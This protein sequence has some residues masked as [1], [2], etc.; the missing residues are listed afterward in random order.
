VGE[1]FAEALGTAER[2]EFIARL[3]RAIASGDAIRRSAVAY[4]TGVK[5]TRGRARTRP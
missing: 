2:E 1:V 4:L 3:A 5:P